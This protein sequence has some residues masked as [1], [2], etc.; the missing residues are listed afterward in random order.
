MEVYAFV[1]AAGVGARMGATQPKQYLPLLDQTVAEHTLKRLLQYPQIKQVVVGVGPD[2]THWQTLAIAKQVTT[3]TGGASRAETVRNGLAYLREQA[4]EDAWVLVHDMAR[5]CIHGQDLDALLAT[6][7][8]DG[9][10]LGVPVADTLK[11]V[12]SQVIQTTVD[13][14]LIWRAF[15]PQFFPMAKLFDALSQGLQQH[16]VITDEAS[17]MEQ[18][19]WHPQMVR[20]R[21][22]NIKIT[23]PEDLALAE[24]YLQKQAQELSE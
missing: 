11:Q 14:E 22:D 23:W 5:P 20:G 15:T 9:A 21:S 18:A 4:N 10:I 8:D 12:D 2:D 6:Q 17:A 1:P 7:C 3:I 19:G 16:R 13:R 24:F